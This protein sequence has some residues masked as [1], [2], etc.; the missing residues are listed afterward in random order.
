MKKLILFL[1]DFIKGNKARNEK[2]SG[3][4]LSIAKEIIRNLGEEIYVSSK[5]GEKTKFE[6]TIHRNKEIDKMA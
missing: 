1:K 5:Q 6:F 3:L 2:G 4:G